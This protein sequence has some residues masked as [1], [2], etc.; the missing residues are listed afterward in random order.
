L[1][2]LTT[3]VT[4]QRFEFR[5]LIQQTIDARRLGQEEASTRFREEVTAALPLEKIKAK[6]AAGT[7]VGIDLV[8]DMP[9][10]RRINDPQRFAATL[11][12]F[13]FNVTVSGMKVVAGSDGSVFLIPWAV[14]LVNYTLPSSQAM[15]LWESDAVLSLI[16]SMLSNDAVV[17][18]MY[19]AQETLRRLCQAVRFC[20]ALQH[21]RGPASAQAQVASDVTSAARAD[22]RSLA[23]AQRVL[24]RCRGV[25]DPLVAEWA[26]APDDRSGGRQTEMPSM[27][28]TFEIA[29]AANPNAPL[30][31]FLEQRLRSGRASLNAGLCAVVLLTRWFMPRLD[32]LGTLSSFFALE[33]P[34]VPVLAWME[35]VGFPIDASNLAL[36]RRAMDERVKILTAEANAETKR[37]NWSLSAPQQCAAMLFDVLQLPSLE[38]TDQA[39][40]LASIRRG[41]AQRGGLRET[42]STKQ[43]VLLQLQRLYPHV[44]LPFIIQEFRTLTG[45]QEKFIAPLVE[46]AIASPFAIAGAAGTYA[47][48]TPLLPRVHG[49]Y[50]HTATAT[51]RLAMGEPNLQTIPHP[52]CF[53]VT[54]ESAVVPLRLRDVFVPTGGGSQYDTIVVAD[55]CQIEARLLA[56]FSQDE[57]FLAAFR[58]DAVD[59]FVALAAKVF[60]VAPVLVAGDSGDDNATVDG[61]PNISARCPPPTARGEA[62]NVSVV[63]KGVTPAQRRQ[64]KT[65]CYGMLYGRGAASIAE[66][67]GLTLSEA[68]ELL[69]TFRSTYAMTT[70]Y[71]REVAEEALKAGFV[72][73]IS[74][75][76]RWL[77]NSSRRGPPKEAASHR[78]AVERIAV[79]SKCQGSA[80]DLVK[81]AMAKLTVAFANMCT[82]NGMPAA[83]LLHQVHDE[84][85][86]ECS[87]AMV[88][89]VVETMRDTMSDVV[90]A[91]SLS[92][93]FPVKVRQGGSWG[94][95]N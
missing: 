12:D 5:E 68:D 70:R 1:A 93:P 7:P 20:D 67:L 15:P 62:G 95:L 80:A 88:Q 10:N 43:T 52:V 54:E 74:G 57:V 28:S 46:S 36:L 39:K 78:A 56:H 25:A 17:P 22:D 87:G 83:R 55:Y 8:V 49:S 40:H 81:L 76:R 89:Q 86:V 11:Q 34:M 41:K 48:G 9:P 50:F 63:V 60:Q 92:L 58:N 37:T 26:L 73:T 77:P 24:A 79:N 69:S 38:D 31:A 32:S 23:A 29:S 47:G 53:S 72:E 45:W 4:L 30:A 64:C 14:T 2:D 75:R 27:I 90:A 51:G 44:A 3:L 65:L 66:E 82:T 91:F 59:V 61:V 16:A 21:H 13:T 42:R 33:V 94:R 85:L 18:V 84:I 35:L 6:K 71:L 19:N